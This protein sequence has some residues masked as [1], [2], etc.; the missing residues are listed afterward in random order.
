MSVFKACKLG[1]RAVRSQNIMLWAGE[2]KV[3][4]PDRH[5][6]YID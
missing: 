3:G 6:V 4:I 2:F 1:R 5:I